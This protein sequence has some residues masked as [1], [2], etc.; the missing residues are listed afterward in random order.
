MRYLR[1]ISALFLIA[2]ATANSFSQGKNGSRIIPEPVFIKFLDGS[3]A[4]TAMT[5]F[6]MPFNSVKNSALP[7]ILSELFYKSTGIRPEVITAT[8]K[9]ARSGLNLILNSDWD[10]TIREEGYNLTVED[11]IIRIAA[12]TEAG[13]FYGFQTLLQLIP[14]GDEDNILSGQKKI[15]IPCVEVT[16][17]PRFQWRGLMLDV[18]RH[19]FTLDEVKKMI[20]EMVQ[21]KFNI[22]HLHLS[23][24]QGWR[25]EIKELP[26]LTKTGAWRVPRTGLWWEREP[27]AEGE[28][29][30]YGGFYTQDQI[31]DLVKY[32]SERHVQILPEIDVPGHSRA[33]IALITI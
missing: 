10:S 21:Y 1:I 18:C 6:Y 22:L 19:F 33:A 7:N 24:D 32:A 31:I 27:P 15:E 20:D 11:K 3:Y 16:D 25:I 29:A 30:S 9:K 26:D 12:N 13:L 28:P 5:K 17:Y 2:V 4:V 8:N 23:D 14:P